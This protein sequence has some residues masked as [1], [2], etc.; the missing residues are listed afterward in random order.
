MIGKAFTYL[1][2]CGLLCG[3]PKPVVASDA[4][5]SELSSRLL[6][7]ALK[8]GGFV[9]FAAHITADEASGERSISF[10]DMPTR[11]TTS[12]T[13]VDDDNVIHR[14]VSDTSDN[15]FIG[16]DLA[17]RPDAAAKRFEVQAKPLDAEFARRLGSRNS[18]GSDTREPSTASATQLSSAAPRVIADGEAFTLEVAVNPQTGVRIID[19]VRM[20]FDESVLRE[21]VPTAAPARDFTRAGGMMQISNYKLLRDGEQ[22]A[23]GGATG[24]CAGPVIWFAL[25]GDG[26]FIFSLVPTVGYDFRRIGTVRHNVL[27]FEW[28]GQHYEWVSSAPVVDGGGN[29]HVWVLHDAEFGAPAQ[30]AGPAG[31]LGALGLGHVGVS[32]PGRRARSKSGSRMPSAAEPGVEDKEQRGRIRIGAAEFIEDL[33]PRR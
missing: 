2:L 14:V 20:S 15:R 30:A 5:T 7:V 12:Q 28:K 8:G 17:V 9:A 13:Q 27:R 29:W 18:S 11:A 1:A 32:G 4:K 16:Y 33:L 6:V 25:P 19:V 23:G 21:G 10:L 3:L 31:I 26:R 22:A 24:G